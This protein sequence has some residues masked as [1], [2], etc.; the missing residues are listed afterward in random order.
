MP[1]R[2]ASVKSKMLLN[3]YE[4]PI[5]PFLEQIKQTTNLKAPTSQIHSIK[6]NKVKFRANLDKIKSDKRQHHFRLKNKQN[7]HAEITKQLKLMESKSA[8]LRNRMGKKMHDLRI[9]KFYSNKKNNIKSFKYKMH[10]L[11]EYNKERKYEEWMA[12]SMKVQS[13]KS[14]LR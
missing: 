11:S 12:R 1:R 3:P 10:L 14:K 13:Q 5:N 2:S 9:E 8:F 6:L 4:S 7:S